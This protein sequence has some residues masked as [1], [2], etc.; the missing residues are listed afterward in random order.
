[1]SEPAMRRLV[2]GLGPAGRRE[3]LRVLTSADDIRGDV[4]RRFCERPGGEEMA[5]LLMFLEEKEWAR[6]AM[7]EELQRE[8]AAD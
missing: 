8:I 6:Q 7:I 1:M 4:I 2:E 5:E 3:L